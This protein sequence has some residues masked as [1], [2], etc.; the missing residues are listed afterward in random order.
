MSAAPQ[1]LHFNFFSVS[2]IAYNYVHILF[3]EFQKCLNWEISEEKRKHNFLY[4][5]EKIQRNLPWRNRLFKLLLLASVSVKHSP[6]SRALQPADPEAQP[7]SH[8]QH[9]YEET[10]KSGIR[11]D[12]LHPKS[13]ICSFSG[14][15]L[16]P[17]F[18]AA[19]WKKLNKYIYCSKKLNVWTPAWFNYLGFGSL[20]DPS[21]RAHMWMQEWGWINKA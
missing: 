11:F 17:Q 5:G 18:I 13:N 4:T 9:T 15:L 6:W 21:D 16:R 10:H 12:S 8:I 1:I 3:W 20:V 2:S 14:R 19:S 7:L